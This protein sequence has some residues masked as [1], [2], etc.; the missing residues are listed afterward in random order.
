M[1]N[2]NKSIYLASYKKDVFKSLLHRAYH[3]FAVSATLQ[4]N[5]VQKKNT[6]SQVKHIEVV[7]KTTMFFVRYT[8]KPN[9]KIEPDDKVNSYVEK[10]IK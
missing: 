9:F 1:Q 7:E 2:K 3:N 6:Y 10:K 4:L 8:S 5:I